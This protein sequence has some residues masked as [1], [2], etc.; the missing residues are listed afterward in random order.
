MKN[1][2]LTPETR[3][4]G[5]YV[6]LHKSPRGHPSGAALASIHVFL[7]PFLLRGALGPAVQENEGGGVMFAM[8]RTRGGEKVFFLRLLLSFLAVSGWKWK[9]IFV[10]PTLSSSFQ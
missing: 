8:G 2:N 10:L 5:L 3:P 6:S 9:N 4:T 1:A 7:F